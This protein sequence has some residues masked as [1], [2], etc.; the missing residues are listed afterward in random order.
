MQ[1]GEPETLAHNGG[2]GGIYGYTQFLTKSGV[3]AALQQIAAIKVSVWVHTRRHFGKIHGRSVFHE[4]ASI[5]AGRIVPGR[6]SL[7]GRHGGAG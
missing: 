5:A 7:T 1:L 3:V 4:S 6:K 2:V